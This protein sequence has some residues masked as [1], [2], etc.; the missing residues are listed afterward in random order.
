MFLSLGFNIIPAVGLLAWSAEYFRRSFALSPADYAMYSGSISIVVAPLGALFGSWLAERF[1]AR[2]RDDAN[3]RVVLL[4]FILNT[5]GL[6]ALTL[7]PSVWVALAIFG[8]TQFV[9]MWVPGP[10][11]AA[12]QVVTPNEMRGQITALFLFIFNIIGYG[13]GPSIVAFITQYVFRDPAM[14]RYSMLIVMIVMMPPAALSIW[15]GLKAYGQSV[16]RARSWA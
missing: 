14:L 11:N 16:A 13:T 3:M 9:A 8:Y 5:P 12:L 2:G 6:I 4:A 10:F 7:A 15:W 1:H